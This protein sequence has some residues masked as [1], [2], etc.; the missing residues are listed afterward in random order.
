[1][2]A[3]FKKPEPMPVTDIQWN[4]E[5]PRA[6]TDLA[7]LIGSISAVGIIQPIT[8]S[9]DGKLLAGKRRLAAAVQLGLTAV[10]AFMVDLDQV[11]EEIASIDDNIMHLPLNSFE[12]DE[13]MFRRKVLYE[14]KYPNTRAGVAGAVKSDVPAFT[15]DA[16]KRL[17][18]SRKSVE[19]AVNRA[20]LATPKVKEARA[21]G[22]A[23]SKV[24]EIVTLDPLL[25]DEVLP[26][27]DGKSYGQVKDIIKRIKDAGLEEAIKEMH[28]KPVSPVAET[29]DRVLAHTQ[30]EFTNALRVQAS[31][32]IGPRDK[33]VKRT[34]G[35]MRLMRSF[36]VR[37][38]HESETI[39]PKES[40]TGTAHEQTL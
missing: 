8:V 6:K 20:K 15:E 2:T 11:E 19:L 22:L 16:A 12:Y 28:S 30:K 27:L 29:L 18:V 13:A 37:V 24:N 7:D 38:K 14:S 31:F 32:G 39:A 33:V 25:Q 35:V 10:P 21:K 3:F 1:M 34:R 23:P 36:L 26:L 17:D 5:H 4:P 40:M 9:K